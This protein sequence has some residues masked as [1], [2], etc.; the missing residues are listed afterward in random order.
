M[1]IY[2]PPRCGNSDRRWREMPENPTD[3]TRVLDQASQ[4]N[5]RAVDELFAMVYD[6]LRH[7]AGGLMSAERASHTLQRTALVNEAYLQLFGTRVHFHSHLHVFNAAALAMRRILLAH[8]AAKSA[9]QPAG[10]WAGI[11]H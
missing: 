7:R 1:T 9:Q 10:G 4:G 2:P 5:P 8:P 3:I 6:D 11:S